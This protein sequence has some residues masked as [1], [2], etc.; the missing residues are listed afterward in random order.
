MNLKEVFDILRPIMQEHQRMEDA[1]EKDASERRK[2]CCVASYSEGYKDGVIESEP[3][4]N[5]WESVNKKMPEH[6]QIVLVMDEHGEMSV[7]KYEVNMATAI[8]YF[9]L[10]NT[11]HQVQKVTHWMNLPKAPNK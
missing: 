2:P 6:N 8:Y 3:Y 1:M 9:I 5:C 4:M 10:Y 11:S 7:C